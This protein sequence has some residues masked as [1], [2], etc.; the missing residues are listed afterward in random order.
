MTT[1]GIAWFVNLI[2]AIFIYDTD[3]AAATMWT[4]LS[5]VAIIVCFL[6]IEMPI[7]V[8]PF[9]IGEATGLIST[10]VVSSNGADD[11]K[12]AKWIIS[13][14]AIMLLAFVVCCYCATRLR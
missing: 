4:W 11:R 10:L 6:A 7:S 9:I 12:A 8:A 3:E 1:F 13:F 14:N 2:A 5:G